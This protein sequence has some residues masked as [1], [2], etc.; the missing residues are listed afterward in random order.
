MPPASATKIKS[1]NGIQLDLINQ[2]LRSHRLSPNPESKRLGGATGD[3]NA[4]TLRHLQTTIAP[5]AGS[6]RRRD[7][8]EID[9]GTGRGGTDGMGGCEAMTT[10]SEPGSAAT[11]G[12]LLGFLRGEIGI[13][14]D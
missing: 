3:R 5:S 6:D 4:V 2:L 8:P 10:G 9:D 12:I 1:G 7:Q 11:G 14:S 13:G